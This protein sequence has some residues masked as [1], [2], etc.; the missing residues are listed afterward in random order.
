MTYTLWREPFKIKIRQNYSTKNLLYTLLLT[1]IQKNPENPEN[2]E[3]GK[4][5]GSGFRKIFDLKNIQNRILKG[6][7]E[8]KFVS[9]TSPSPKGLHRPRVIWL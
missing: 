4:K 5:S 3:S 2:I 6:V 7:F 1:K 8:V 9:K